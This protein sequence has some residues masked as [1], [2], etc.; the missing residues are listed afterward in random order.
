M[1]SMRLRGL[2]QKLSGNSNFN[3]EWTKINLADEN[4]FKANYT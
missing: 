1:V 2:R 3:I 4:N